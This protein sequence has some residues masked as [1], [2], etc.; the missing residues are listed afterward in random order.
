MIRRYLLDSGI[1]QDFQSNRY[2]IQSRAKDL[3]RAGHRVGNCTPVLGELCAGLEFSTSTRH[4]RN[5]QRLEYALSWLTHWPFTDD[6]AREYGRI[7]AELRRNGITI[8]QIDMQIAAVA[9]I[10]TNCIVVSKD[11]DLAR[12]SGITVE[13]W[14]KA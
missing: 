8:Q 2:G 7:Y 11:S 10:M 3:K 13:D 5:K 9:R 4:E 1:A 6:A 14:S 12:V